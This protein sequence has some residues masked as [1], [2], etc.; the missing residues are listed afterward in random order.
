MLVGISYKQLFSLEFL[1]SRIKSN[2]TNFLPIYLDLNVNRRARYSA[3][4]NPVVKPILWDDLND[5]RRLPNKIFI[6]LACFSIYEYVHMRL[7]ISK[8]DLYYITNV[9]LNLKKEL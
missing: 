9:M 3:I 5:L 4:A 6:D 1:R 7:C 8:T 2:Y